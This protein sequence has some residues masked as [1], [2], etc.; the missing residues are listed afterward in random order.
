MV[1]KSGFVFTMACGADVCAAVADDV[2]PA[3]IAP[4]VV[5]AISCFFI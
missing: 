1:M 2:H 4:K 5:R 3:R